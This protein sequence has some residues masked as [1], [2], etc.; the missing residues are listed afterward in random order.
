MIFL[1]LLQGFCLLSH[2]LLGDTDG[3]YGHR[4]R[5]DQHDDQHRDIA[6]HRLHFVRVPGGHLL[7]GGRQGP[8][9]VCPPVGGIAVE[10]E[11]K[12]DEAEAHAAAGIVSLPLPKQLGKDRQ[13]HDDDDEGKVR[14]PRDQAD[15]E[16][17]AV[18]HSRGAEA[19]H[20]GGCVQVDKSHQQGQE[21]A[22]VGV[23][24]RM[25]HAAGRPDD[26]Q[27][28]VDHHGYGDP[29]NRTFFHDILPFC[30]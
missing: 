27:Q 28:Q 11:G 10:A 2:D 1:F 23:A 20:M 5:Q 14:L 9:R 13:D 6:D 24:R 19:L 15:D 17:R 16:G 8:R 29:Q 21:C 30:G 12:G 7:H 22:G 26:V 4:D 18:K 3:E 25:N